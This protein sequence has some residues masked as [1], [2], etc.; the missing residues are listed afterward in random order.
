MSRQKS[1]RMI[2]R[3]RKKN[4]SHNFLSQIQPQEAY[5]KW[6]VTAPEKRPRSVMCKQRRLLLSS[7]I[8]RFINFHPQISRVI[9]SSSSFRLRA[10]LGL[11]DNCANKKH[12]LCSTAIECPSE[13]D[14]NVLPPRR[15]DY[16]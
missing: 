11:G 9:K 5:S 6:V 12:F 1:V 2:Q 7:K 16:V 14:T 4:F 15:V 13:Q 3:N 8:L 10:S